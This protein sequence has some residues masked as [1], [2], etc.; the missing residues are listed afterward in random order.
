MAL[1]WAAAATCFFHENG[2]GESNAAVVV[3]SITKE[4]LER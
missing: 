3:N 2:M 1:I 4:W